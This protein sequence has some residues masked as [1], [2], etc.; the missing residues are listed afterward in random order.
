[1][2]LDNYIP[3]AYVTRNTKTTKHII[4]IKTPDS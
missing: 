4:L 3:V 2:Q 1:M